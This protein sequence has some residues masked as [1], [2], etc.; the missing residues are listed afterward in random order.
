MTPEET[1]FTNSELKRH[2]PLLL[3]EFYEK[4]L[5]VNIRK[6]GGGNDAGAD[7]GQEEKI[8]VE[9]TDGE[10]VEMLGDETA[11]GNEETKE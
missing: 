7:C 10:M 1:V 11:Q 4:M 6:E 5:K 3:C 2:N 9:G 8:M